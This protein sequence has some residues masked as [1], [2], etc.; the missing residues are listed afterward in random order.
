[1]A[2]STNPFNDL[3]T[4]DTSKL[5][6]SIST[7]S[8][9]ASNKLD[10]DAFVKILT[11]EMSHQ[12]P[13]N[14][15][16]STEFVA[17]MAQFSSVE[18]MLNLNRTMT[19]NGASSLVGKGVTMNEQDSD[20]NPYRG[21][22]QKVTRSGDDIKVFVS[23]VDGNGNPEY[24]E[25]LDGNGN[26]VVKDGKIQYVT[27]PK[28]K[29]DANGD[30]VIDPSTGKPVYEDVKVGKVMSFDY[31]DVAGVIGDYDVIDTE[32][33]AEDSSKSTSDTTANTSNT[34]SASNTSGTSN[35]SSAG[36]KSSTTSTT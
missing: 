1:M 9:N 36:D 4:I 2:S 12:S 23:L 15:Q 20:G 33:Y 22:V 25:Q 7:T 28:V 8:R 35:A 13:D 18:Q 14:T 3:N 21:V 29:T 26:P 32:K 27:E 30:A 6:N 19:F 17:Q 31:S 16:D 34:S 5:S 10:Q 11:A 24:Q